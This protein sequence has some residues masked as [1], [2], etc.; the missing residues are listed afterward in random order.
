[1]RSCRMFGSGI[2]SR[3]R[4]LGGRHPAP[5]TAGKHLTTVR[6]GSRRRRGFFYAPAYWSDDESFAICHPV[7]D[8]VLRRS[9]R[10]KT[11]CFDES[12][13][14]RSGVWETVWSLR[15][16]FRLFHRVRIRLSKNSTSTTGE[17][18]SREEGVRSMFSANAFRK[19]QS[20]ARRKMDQTPDFAIPLASTTRAVPIHPRPAKLPVPL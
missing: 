3:D 9:S 11:P 13:A 5:P 18:Q 7:K 19:W 20:F 12:H 14:R 4:M 15:H 2:H 17:L 10:A 1:M 8:G 6:T 16:M